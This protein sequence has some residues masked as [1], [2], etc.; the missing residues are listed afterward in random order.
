MKHSIR[1]EG[2][3]FRLRPIGLDDASKIIEIRNQNSDKNKYIHPVS[4]ILSDQILWIENYFEIQNDYYFAIENKFDDQ[5]EGFIGLYNIDQSTGEWG[6]WVL[7]DGSLS[8][9]ESFALVHLIGFNILN[10]SSIYSIT[11]SEN[12]RVIDFH[13]KT[14]AEQAGIIENFFDLNGTIFSGIKHIHYKGPFFDKTYPVIRIQIEKLFKRNIRSYIEKFEF[15]HIGIVSENIEDELPL[16]YLQNYS[17]EDSFFDY[18]Q[19]VRGVFLSS[20]NKPR[21]ELLQ[22]LE[23]FNT[24]SPFISRG[25]KIYHFAYLVESID[26]TIVR[27]VKILGGKLLHKKKSVFFD[28]EIAFVILSNKLIVELI[29][30]QTL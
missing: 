4:N 10:L 29:Q 6:R 18:E 23:G 16:F 9:T 27:L 26:H 14:F 7:K 21:L 28:A 12:Y 15:H 17:K 19:G 5:V 20:K 3:N 1:I 22:N 2:L 25:V 24:L 30:K 13:I 8:A 11:V